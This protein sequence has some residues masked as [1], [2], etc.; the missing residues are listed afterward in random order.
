MVSCLS[1]DALITMLLWG[2]VDDFDDNDVDGL[3]WH[4]D[5][6]LCLVVV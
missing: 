2:N 5:E 3:N 4:H 1:N 6:V